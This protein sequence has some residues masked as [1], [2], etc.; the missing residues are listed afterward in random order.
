[1]LEFFP[2][3]IVKIVTKVT[4]LGPKTPLV[5]CKIDFFMNRGSYLF[6]YFS[7]S[8]KASEVVFDRL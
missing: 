1:M 3:A 5:K 6:V 2:A 4:F 7:M 8:V